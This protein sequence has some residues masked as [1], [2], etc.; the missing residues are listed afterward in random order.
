MRPKR[1]RPLH[2]RISAANATDHTAWS[3]AGYVALDIG[4]YQDAYSD[5]AKAVDIYLK[6]TS[7]HTVT[8]EVDLTWGLMLAEYFSGHVKEAKETYGGFKKEYPD[9]VSITTLKQLPLIWSTQT[10]AL[11][12]KMQRDLR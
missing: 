12:G 1:S 4:Q 10:Q 2:E 11:I 5:F 6:D 8:Q 3:N 7:K 9:F